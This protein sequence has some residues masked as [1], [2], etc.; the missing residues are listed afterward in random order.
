VGRTVVIFGSNSAS[1]IRISAVRHEGPRY[2][3]GKIRFL[4]SEH[5]VKI[6]LSVIR[7]VGDAF[8]NRG[9]E[10]GGIER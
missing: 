3:L 7:F 1:W 6:R 2:G 10:R 5:V 4:V 8:G 9:V